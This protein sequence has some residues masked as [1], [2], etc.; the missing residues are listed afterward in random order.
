MLQLCQTLLGINKITYWG[1]IESRN[2]KSHQKKME[3]SIF[4]LTPVFGICI[5]PKI[6]VATL[7]SIDKS[8]LVVGG[9]K[10]NFNVSPGPKPVDIDLTLT[11]QDLVRGHGPDLE[12]DKKWKFPSFF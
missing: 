8:F 4:C 7:I 10:T 6:F 2:K 5:C 3:I 12:L 1:K 9:C 11:G